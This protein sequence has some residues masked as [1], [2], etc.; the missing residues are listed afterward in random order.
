MGW[1]EGE[2]VGWGVGWGEGEKVGVV[3][4][5]GGGGEEVGR[6][7]DSLAVSTSW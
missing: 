6:K 1:G 7:G 4:R 2:K 5:W 3:R